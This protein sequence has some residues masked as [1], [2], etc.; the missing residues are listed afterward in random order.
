MGDWVHVVR[1]SLRLGRHYWEYRMF[2]EFCSYLSNVE[3]TFWLALI[4][5]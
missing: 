1:I 2:D 4:V 3:T 5:N